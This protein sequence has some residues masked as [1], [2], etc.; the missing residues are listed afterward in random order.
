MT[1][2][3]SASTRPAWSQMMQGL[4]EH[5]TVEKVERRLREIAERELV[6]TR[7]NTFEV[8]AIDDELHRITIHCDRTALFTVEYRLHPQ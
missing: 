4:I 1:I 2:Y 8:L 5:G 6:R 3:I 7:A